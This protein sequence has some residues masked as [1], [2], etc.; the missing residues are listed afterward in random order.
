M[1]RGLLAVN[2]RRYPLLLDSATSGPRGRWTILAAAPRY[3]LSLSASGRLGRSDGAST[4][5]GGFL[6]A[7]EE[8]WQHE[9]QPALSPPE[10][11]PFIGGW[12]VFLGYEVAVEIER[13]LQ[14]PRSPD[15]W[16]AFAL[17]I[18]A[19]LLYDRQSG[20]SFAVAEPGEER[21]LAEL[22]ADLERVPAT[23]RAAADGRLVGEVLEEPAERFLERVE[24]VQAAIAAGDIYQANLAR[25]W[26]ARTA[27]GF[28]PHLLYERLRRANPAP[29]AAFLD[30]QGMTVLSSSPERLL[31]IAHGR[32][33]TRP[34][35]GTYPR[36]PDRIADASEIAE[37]VA[38]PKER[39]E[40]V[41][42]IDLERNDLGRVCEAGSI[43]VD[44]FMAVESYPHVHHLVSSVAGRLRARVSPVAALRAVFPGGTI[45]GCPKIR[46]MELVAREEDGGR[47]A[48]TG[49]LGYIGHDGSADFNILI[50][51]I[52]VARDQVVLRTGAGIVADSDPVRELAE[53]R[54]KARGMI[55]ALEAIR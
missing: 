8:C 54:A 55:A 27:A 9:R 51:S 48:Y 38:H 32:I 14:L 39:A 24:H 37:L 7:L 22:V 47:G 35:A 5:V 34:I 52:T 30:W 46:C 25:A 41:M 40:H 42:L 1:L 19:A 16:Q 20:K 50:R 15:P 3:A 6:A 43:E 36:D 33:S 18:P 45:T 49:S 17:R 31:H 23:A 26:R 10:P 44:E 28:D 4:A 2:P 21:L 12:C 53:T 13:R 11:L 29:F